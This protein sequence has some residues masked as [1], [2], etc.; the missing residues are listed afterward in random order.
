M[1]VEYP[2]D[3][4]I[5]V[6][7]GDEDV[8]RV[9][10]MVIVCVMSVPHISLTLPVMSPIVRGLASVRPTRCGASKPFARITRRTPGTCANA[11]EAQSRP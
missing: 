5:G 1:L 9:F 8:G 4:R 6:F 10:R 2:D 3:F 11:R 7:H